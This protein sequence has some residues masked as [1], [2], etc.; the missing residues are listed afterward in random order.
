MVDITDF[1][2]VE[3]YRQ[4]LRMYRL[5]RDYPIE[6]IRHKG[7]EHLPGIE[8]HVGG[9]YFAKL[10]RDWRD[11]LWDSDSDRIRE[12]ALDTTQYGIDMRQI[13]PFQGVM[14]QEDVSRVIKDSRDEQRRVLSSAQSFV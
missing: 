12:I 11:A 14:S 4:W 13:N 2:S 3:E 9:E 1:R 7:L 6:S 5:F 10:M 8:R